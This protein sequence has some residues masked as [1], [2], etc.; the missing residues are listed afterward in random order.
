MSISHFACNTPAFEDWF[1]G[2]NVSAF[3]HQ[4][5][6]R[7]KNAGRGR[8]VGGSCRRACQDASLLQ[9]EAPVGNT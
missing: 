6:P 3:N 2:S 1:A 9:L 5:I 8:I 7:E 4:S